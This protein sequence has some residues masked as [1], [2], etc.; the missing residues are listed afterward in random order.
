MLK[1]KLIQIDFTKKGYSEIKFKKLPGE[2]A[3]EYQ[4]SYSYNYKYKKGYGYI[5]N[6]NIILSVLLDNNLL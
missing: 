1:I 3:K 6:D 2:I 5:L 4:Y